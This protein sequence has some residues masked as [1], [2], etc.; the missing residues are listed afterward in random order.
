MPLYDL[1][2]KNGHEQLDVYLKVGERPPCPT[3]GEPTDTLWRTSSNIIADEIPGGIWIAH[4]ICNDDGTPK[5]YYSKSEIARAA[6]EKGLTNRV[7]HI[8]E[9]GTDKNKYTKRWV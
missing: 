6:K 2:C 5:K 7:E 9:P 3:C 4:G 8:T 1:T